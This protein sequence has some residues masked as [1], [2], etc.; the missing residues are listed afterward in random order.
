MIIGHDFFGLADEGTNGAYWDTP[1]ATDMM[2]ELQLNEGVYDEAYINLD[3]DIVDNKDKPEKWSLTTIMDAEFTGDLDGGSV[4]ADGFT[5]T[6][7]QLYRS[8]YGSNKW[9]AIGQFDYTPEFNVYEYVDRYTQNGAT[10]QYGIVP[11]ANEVLGDMSLSD[12]VKAE[13]EG[14]YLTDKNE[15]RK[16]EYDVTLGDV[17]YNKNSSMN[18]PINSKYPVATFGNSNYRSGNLSV[19]PL[20]RET[21]ELAGNDI[22]KL[23]EQVNR[24]E[25]LDFINNGRAKVLRMDSGVLMLVVAQN[26]IVTHKEMEALR[27]LASISF[28]YTEIG[29][30][31]FETMTKSNLVPSGYGAKMTYDDEGGVVVG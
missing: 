25:W 7:I 10:Y 27:S 23:A 30:L 29:D 5:I 15:N 22:D 13:F 16:F 28:D 31:N 8:V 24:Q 6:E 2:D 11:K 14:M 19:L 4:G 20:S 17:A 1:I 3:T 12:T 9:D 26:A 21:V 18:Q